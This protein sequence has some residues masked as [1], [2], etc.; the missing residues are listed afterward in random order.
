M[1]IRILV[2]SFSLVDRVGSWLYCIGKDILSKKSLLG[3]YPLRR[4]V[5]QDKYLYLLMLVYLLLIYL[6]IWLL[7]DKRR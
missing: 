7:N 6:S 1:E 2:C 4:R 5:L 3:F